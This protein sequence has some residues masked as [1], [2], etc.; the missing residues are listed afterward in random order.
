MSGSFSAQ[1]GFPPASRFP[2][3]YRHNG[4]SGNGTRAGTIPIFPFRADRE[5]RERRGSSTTPIP[6]GEYGGSFL[7]SANRAAPARGKAPVSAK[8]DVSRRGSENGL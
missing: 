5:K 2:L 6:R 4:K 7:P 3:S 8:A 1:R